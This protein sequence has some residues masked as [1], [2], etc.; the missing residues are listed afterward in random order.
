MSVD[1]SEYFISDPRLKLFHSHRASAK[2]SG[3][4]LASE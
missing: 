3:V 2:A 1:W 4:D